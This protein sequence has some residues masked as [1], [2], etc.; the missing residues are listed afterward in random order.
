MIIMHADTKR[1]IG[2]FFGI[3][4]GMTLALI[5]TANVLAFAMVDSVYE[6][7]RTVWALY[8]TGV[9][10]NWLLHAPAIRTERMR[11]HKNLVLKIWLAFAVL[12][13]LL[14]TAA[15]LAEAVT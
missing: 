9:L 6:A 10:A 15:L 13:F 3:V 12:A 4:T 5:F 2:R 14:L 8:A 1:D 11:W 7:L